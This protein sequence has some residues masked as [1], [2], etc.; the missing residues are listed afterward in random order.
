MTTSAGDVVSSNQF[1]GDVTSQTAVQLVDTGTMASPTTIANN[2]IIM[3]GAKFITLDAGHS[4][5]AEA[6][7]ALLAALRGFL[8]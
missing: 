3:A 8:G 2:T 7:A 5:M 6:P 4:I 1:F